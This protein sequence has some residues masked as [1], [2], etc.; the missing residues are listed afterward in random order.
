MNQF[1]PVHLAGLDA[2]SLRK[3][4]EFV[5]VFHDAVSLLRYDEKVR[6]SMR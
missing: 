1:G 3:H 4:F 2:V 5:V 6:T